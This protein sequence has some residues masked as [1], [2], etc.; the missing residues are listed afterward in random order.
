MSP[1]P[2]GY[3]ISNLSRLKSENRHQTTQLPPFSTFARCALPPPSLM[4]YLSAP[5]I[6]TPPPNTSSFASTLPPVSPCSYGPYPASPCS[7]M[8]YPTPPRPVLPPISLL[9]ASQSSIPICY[10]GGSFP[11]KI[12]GSRGLELPDV[13]S[14]IKPRVH[15]VS[16]VPPQMLE[17]VAGGS[18][19]SPGLVECIWP[20][21][22]TA[23]APIEMEF[24]KCHLKSHYTHSMELEDGREG[25]RCPCGKPVA[26][27]NWISHLRGHDDRFFIKCAECNRRILVTRL[28]IH[29][30]KAHPTTADDGA[31]GRGGEDHA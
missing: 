15:E 10:T 3:S 11:C 25:C 21:C 29:M 7:T 30:G 17:P 16:E 26:E 5:R 4:M 23:A 20:G 6:A 12:R 2:Q 27:N 31:S 18:T 19:L 8:S 14:P 1:N 9:G 22:T 24:W 28:E 13:D